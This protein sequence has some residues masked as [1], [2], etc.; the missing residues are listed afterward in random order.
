MQTT[1]STY[2]A[3]GFAAFLAACD[4]AQPTE[5]AQAA[6]FT[7]PIDAAAMKLSAPIAAS[8]VAP[9][10]NR[11]QLT[12]R[13]MS[14][15]ETG[16]EIHR[17]WTP[18]GAFA[19]LATTSAGIAS[20]TD[21]TV[22]P[23]DQY[24]YRVRAF[25]VMSAGRSIYS[26]FSNTTCATPVLAAPSSVTAAPV[27]ETQITI[28]WQEN[29]SYE[30]GIEI[31]RAL[32]FPGASYSLR[33]T[34]GP[35]GTGHSDEGLEPGTQYC[36]KVRVFRTASGTTSYSVFSTA[37]CATTLVP[38]PTAP[39]GAAA[40]PSSSSAVSLFWS[41]NSS[42]EAFFRI[43]RSS[44][45]G[46]VWSLYGTAYANATRA[47]GLPAVAEQEV[48]YRVVAVNDAGE[49]ASDPACTTPPTGPTNLVVTGVD[50]TTIA[51]TWSDNS[52]V[53]DGY[54]LR[55][56]ETNCIG[57]VCNAF[58]PMCENYGI[59]EQTRVIATLPANSTTYTGPG[60]VSMGHSYAVIYV[61]ATKDGGNSDASDPRVPLTLLE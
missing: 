42:H 26:S 28:G 32:A 17:S 24:C 34:L 33:A 38:A 10:E 31:H 2:S 44:D 40:K 6:D 59:C 41:D 3:F 45:G 53:E 58:D 4:G 55:V 46:M 15:N 60:L 36:Y 7:V 18:D 21:G 23:F 57:P 9:A 19:L 48:C 5:P 12:W 49:A 16:F 1:A 51:A 52:G 13:D 56:F 37:V 61:V 27:S 39:S 47:D 43:E 54:Q 14:T 35:D 50:A 30:T 8:A 11:I 22:E 20:S 29:S 25:R